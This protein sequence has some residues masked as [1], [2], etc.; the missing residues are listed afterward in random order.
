MLH[1]NK[2][3][4]RNM[5]S[6]SKQTEGR[7]FRRP[8]RKDSHQDGKWGLWSRNFTRNPLGSCT[9][10]KSFGS[11][12]NLSKG[13]AN[14]AG[15]IS[16]DAFFSELP[17]QSSPKSC[18][19]SL[20]TRLNLNRVNHSLIGQ[21]ETE[22]HGRFPCQLVGSSWGLSCRAGCRFSRKY[23]NVPGSAVAIEV[24]SLPHHP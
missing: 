3:F 20:K 13:V 19:A 2:D 14:L 16:P 12:Q 5:R 11:L 18:W 24:V 10:F 23:H 7:L 21:V 17:R 1:S 22:L 8:C 15:R 6:N 4:P 9:P